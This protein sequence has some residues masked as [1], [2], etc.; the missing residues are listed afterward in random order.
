MNIEIPALDEE[1]LKEAAAKHAMAGA[2]AEIKDYY[3]GYNSPYRK[4]IKEELEKQD[5]AFPVT[6]PDVLAQINET[7]T[8]EVNKI[9]NNSVSNTFLPMVQKYLTRTEPTT[10]FS[11]ILKEFISHHEGEYEDYTVSVEERLSYGWL[12]VKLHFKE[13][14]THMTLHK[15]HYGK[16]EKR[17]KIL[18]LPKFDEK[19]AYDDSVTV[20]RDGSFKV[21]FS[22]DVLSNNF[23]LFCARV[24]LSESKIIMDVTDFDEDMFE[25]D[26]CHC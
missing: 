15:D 1:K 23:I 10:P 26:E 2:I 18:G 19:G 14:V 25:K 22:K 20:Y 8:A 6:L 5:F 21:P 3:E 11:T 12:D 17:Y 7:L 24:M 9:A 13:E 16:E 4:K